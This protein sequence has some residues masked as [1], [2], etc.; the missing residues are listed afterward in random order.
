MT[1]HHIVEVMMLNAGYMLSSLCLNQISIW[2]SNLHEKHFWQLFFNFN[3]REVRVSVYSTSMPNSFS[4]TCFYMLGQCYT[5]TIWLHGFKHQMQ[6]TQYTCLTQIMPDSINTIRK[7][8]SF[9]FA[10]LFSVLVVVVVV[11]AWLVVVVIEGGRGRS[12]HF[13]DCKSYF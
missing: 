4:L 9:V 5:S 12:L 10:L 7:H 1:Y 6:I 8:I 2:A 11:V 13:V 3:E